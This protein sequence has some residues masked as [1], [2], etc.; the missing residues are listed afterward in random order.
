M[1]VQVR[2]VSLMLKKPTFVKVV[3][4]LY[5]IRYSK[6]LCDKWFLRTGNQVWG[7]IDHDELEIILN[8][9]A[10]ESFLRES[11]L[12]EIQ[13]AVNAVIGRAVD[14]PDEEQYVTVGTPILLA[15]LTDPINKDIFDFI[16]G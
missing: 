10:P 9:K 13:H 2:L 16:F 5:T 14:N 7:Y 11:M 8:D 4:H 1:P 3:N 15:T 12:H 6:E